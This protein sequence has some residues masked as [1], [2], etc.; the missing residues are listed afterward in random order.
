MPFPTRP[1][2]TRVRPYVRAVYGKIE[3]NVPHT[4]SADGRHA[5]V[6][7]QMPIRMPTHMPTRRPARRPVWRGR[8]SMGGTSVRTPTSTPTRASTHRACAAREVIDGW[9][10][11]TATSCGA[12]GLFVAALHT[13]PVHASLQTSVRTFYFFIFF[14]GC[15][16]TSARALARARARTHAGKLGPPEVQAHVQRAGVCG[17]TVD[18]HLAITI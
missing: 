3:A 2:P 10:T 15:L 1:F 5:A 4:C 17:A 14:S 16:C 12:P 6:S 11:A 8:A 7:T 18:H 9:H 13:K